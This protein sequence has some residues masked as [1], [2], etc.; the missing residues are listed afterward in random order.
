MTSSSPSTTTTISVVPHALWC[1]ALST[2][3]L[4]LA[5]EHGGRTQELYD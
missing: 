5:M 3:K 2:C 1:L 4:A